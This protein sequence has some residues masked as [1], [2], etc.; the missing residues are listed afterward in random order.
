VSKNV[1]RA[2]E[3]K[4]TFRKVYIQPPEEFAPQ[5]DT[6]EVEEMTEYEGPTADARR[7]GTR[8]IGLSRTPNGSPLTR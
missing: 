7:L 5:L 4:N 6:A 8:R 1:F 2:Q 3:V